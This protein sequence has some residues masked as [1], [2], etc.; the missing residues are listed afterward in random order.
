MTA[1][2]Y[3]RMLATP[4][5]GTNYVGKGSA[6]PAWADDHTRAEGS[7]CGEYSTSYIVHPLAPRRL[8]TE[9][10]DAKIILF[11]R[12]PIDR[13]YSQ[14]TMQKRAGA[15]RELSFEEV[16][17]M[18][19]EEYPPVREA[20]RE[21]FS[22]GDGECEA[23][24]CFPRMAFQ[25]HSKSGSTY[26]MRNE[27]DLKNFFFTSY[28]GRSVYDDMVE[29]WLTVF[30]RE[31]VKIVQSERFFDEPVAVM[32]EV[33]QWLGLSPFDWAN[34]GV[35]SERWGGGA[36]NAFDPGSYDKLAEETRR[37]LRR[38]F[39]PY[40]ERLFYIIGEEFDWE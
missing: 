23:V 7:V 35:L 18:E 8:Y 27:L 17:N 11:L 12:N 20:F 31:Q 3:Q 21:C 14:F 19:I 25:R 5:G 24:R 33:C 6:R 30:P 4:A 26:L 29:R 36:S 22:A 37:D 10:P 39:R 16:V 9:V 15:E 2:G 34:A 28:V 38:F 13:A 32:T 1:A 40:N